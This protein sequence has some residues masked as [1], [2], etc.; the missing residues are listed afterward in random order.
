MTKTI[1]KA[2][3]LFLALSAATQTVRGYLDEGHT[4]KSS[5][6]GS[7]FWVTDGPFSLKRGGGRGGIP[8]WIGVSVLEVRDFRGRL[9]SLLMLFFCLLSL[10]RWNAEGE[11][12]FLLFAFRDAVAVYLLANREPSDGR[13]TSWAALIS[14]ISWGLPLLYFSAPEPGETKFVWLAANLLTILGFL[15]VILATIDLGKKYGVSPARRG[16]LCTTGLYRFFGSPHVFRLC[17]RPA[18]MGVCPPP[19]WFFVRPFHGPVHHQ[20]QM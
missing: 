6:K 16:S 7:T 9:G 12:Y 17:H 4:L 18:W 5:P 10:L 13:G 20:G 2:A 15:I 14:Y 8:R 11:W 3:A 19:E 1:L